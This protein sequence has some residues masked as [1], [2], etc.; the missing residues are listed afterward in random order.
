MSE[1]QVKVAVVG[2]GYWGKNLVRNFHELG[3]LQTICDADGERAA[4]MGARHQVA[5]TSDFDSVLEDPVINAV[6][7]AVPAV[8]HYEFAKKAML[9]GKDVFCREAPSLAS[10][11]RKRAGGDSAPMRTNPDGWTYFGVASRHPGIGVA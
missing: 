3:S 1:Q 8:R 5:G 9:A 2:C 11:R 10:A 4:E 7:L 6:A